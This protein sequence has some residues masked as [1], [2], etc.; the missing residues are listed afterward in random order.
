MQK[1]TYL[2]LEKLEK[3]E[4]PMAQ[5]HTVVKGDT[6][7]WNSKRV[8]WKWKEI[9]CNFWSKQTNIFSSR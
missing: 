8:L 5:F 9:Y 2:A 4:M 6:C 3:K 1:Q 7:R